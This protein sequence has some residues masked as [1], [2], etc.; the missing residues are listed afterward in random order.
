METERRKQGVAMDQEE[1]EGQKVKE[2]SRSMTEDNMEDE[3]GNER[4]GKGVE[5]ECEKVHE[6]G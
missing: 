1:Q 2:G 6:N 4:K 3:E 5:K